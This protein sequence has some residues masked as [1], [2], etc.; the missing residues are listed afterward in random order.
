M[1]ISARRIEEMLGFEQRVNLREVEVAAVD[2]HIFDQL[3][4]APEVLQ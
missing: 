3:C 1:E 4:T 2:L